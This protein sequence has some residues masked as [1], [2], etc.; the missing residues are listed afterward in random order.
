MNLRD[1]LKKRSHSTD[2]HCHRSTPKLH[3]FI[4]VDG[5]TDKGRKGPSHRLVARFTGRKLKSSHEE[6][7]PNISVEQQNRKSQESNLSESSPVNV[8]SIDAINWF[9]PPMESKILYIDDS[10]DD[11]VDE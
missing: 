3:N 10:D 4:D 5:E 7:F 1:K 11:D 8:P 2:A 6:S 9:S